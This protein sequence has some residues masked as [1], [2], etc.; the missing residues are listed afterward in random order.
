MKTFIVFCLAVSTVFAA[1][2]KWSYPPNPCAINPLGRTYFAHP[3]DSTKFIKCGSN[4]R[5]YVVQ[6]PP[7][8]LYNQGS[9]SCGAKV[10]EPPVVDELA[11]YGVL[12]PCTYQNE[13][14]GQIY[15]GLL[16]YPHKFIQ[17]EPNGNAQ[18]MDC[19]AQTSWDESKLSCVYPKDVTP[20]GSAPFAP[21]IGYVNPCTEEAIAANV[22]FF[23]HADPNKFI[24]C[25]LEG[26]AFVQS[27]PAGLVWSQGLQTCASSRQA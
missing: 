17:C 8:E 6:C 2:C 9:S 20:G 21:L 25:D 24:Q 22:L 16:N 14:D 7:G 26:N 18:V 1:D 10:V 4:S 23:S 3:S 27:C 19:P 12:N 11:K 15:F 13:V 5:M